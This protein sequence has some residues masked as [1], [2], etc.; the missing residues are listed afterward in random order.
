MITSTTGSV[1]GYRVSKYFAPILL[2][3]LSRRHGGAEFWAELAGEAEESWDGFLPDAQQ[4]ALA[5]LER[6]ASALGANG[7][8]GVQFDVSPL[9]DGVRI[10]VTVAGT[11]VLLISEQEYAAE[12]A[13]AA[14]IAEENEIAE[15]ERRS[16]A[17]S[18]LREL[19]Y[20]S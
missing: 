1:D 2:N 16:L 5:G 7:L 15:A 11:P 17:E 19:G 20:W 10:L 18:K 3:R 13:N 4:A 12:L 9:P 14:L 8:L 6:K